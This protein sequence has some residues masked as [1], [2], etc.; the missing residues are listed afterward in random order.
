MLTTLF[1]T[2]IS[3]VGS[4][5]AA[6]DRC[7]PDGVLRTRLALAAAPWRDGTLVAE[8]CVVDANQPSPGDWQQLRFVRTDGNTAW[9]R[10]LGAQDATGEV[11]WSNAE[12]IA[13]DV[14]GDKREEVVVRGQLSN[15]G[16]GGCIVGTGLLY[17]WPDLPDTGGDCGRRGFEEAQRARLLTWESARFD[18]PGWMGPSW[19]RSTVQRAAL[20]DLVVEEVWTALPPASHDPLSYTSHV[21][22]GTLGLLPHCAGEG[23]PGF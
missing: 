1:L 6:P 16:A 4:A 18:V 19:V 2:L 9:T 11:W 21:M 7:S 10:P 22:V 12:L 5:L 14:D 15:C 23:A 20:R 3:V 17:V 8:G 13:E